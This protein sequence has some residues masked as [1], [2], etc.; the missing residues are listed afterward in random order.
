MSFRLRP[1]CEAAT[2]RA[3]QG[4]ETRPPLLASHSTAQ[5]PDRALPLPRSCQ[6]TGPDIHFL[7]P[8]TRI[9]FRVGDD[10]SHI[11]SLC[12]GK[13]AYSHNSLVAVQ[14]WGELGFCNYHPPFTEDRG[15]RSIWHI[16][17]A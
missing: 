14:V 2:G 12:G 10:T 11:M 16:G 13:D 1:P 5:A 15:G 4:L 7:T 17:T 8:R 6:W 9:Y 3:T